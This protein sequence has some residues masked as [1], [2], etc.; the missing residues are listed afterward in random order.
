VN[1]VQYGAR[2]IARL[3]ELADELRKRSPAASSYV[4]PHTTISTG[5]IHGGSAR[6]VVAGECVLEWE[7]R[8]VNR[9]DATHVLE[10]LQEFEAI[11]GEEMAPQ[12]NIV[13]VAEGEVDGLEDDPGSAAIVLMQELL[14]TDTVSTVPFGTEAGLYQQAGITAVVCGPGSIDVAHQPDEYVGLDQL[15]ACLEMIQNLG[16]RLS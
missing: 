11:L 13:T 14:D 8:P 16:V 12:C 6:N 3:M 1:A 10:S 5:R 15:E 4:P 7:M 2:Y 9:A